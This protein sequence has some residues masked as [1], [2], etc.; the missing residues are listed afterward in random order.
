MKLRFA[1]FPL[2]AT[3]CSRAGCVTLTHTE[4]CSAV[5]PARAEP[6]RLQLST[7]AVEEAETATPPPVRTRT[8]I[9]EP[10]S[11]RHVRTGTVPSFDYILNP[12][13]GLYPPSLWKHSRA[14]SRPGGTR[15]AGRPRAA[16]LRGV[17]ARAPGQT[18]GRSPIPAPCRH[19][20]LLSA[21]GSA[22]AAG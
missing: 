13:G 3:R 14:L 10:T 16:P 2:H 21:G 19:C 9:P 5:R 11:S 12:L 1:H 22:A 15:P 6:G 8:C 7:R 18:D 4:R 17:T 20:R